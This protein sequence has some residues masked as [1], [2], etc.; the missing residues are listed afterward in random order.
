MNFLR[1][2]ILPL[3]F[4]LVGCVSAEAVAAPPSAL[5][6]NDLLGCYAQVENGPI[7]MRVNKEVGHY[8]LVAI[9]KD[10]STKGMLTLHSREVKASKTQDAR[11]IDALIS[12]DLGVI[13]IIK[14]KKGARMHGEPPASAFYLYAPQVG[15]P[16]FKKTCPQVQ[17]H[18]P[19][20][21]PSGPR[22]AA[23]QLTR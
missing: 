3:L 21:H 2:A 13:A 6:E 14:F 19:T 1:N 20:S 8:S 18:D 5:R 15:G 23:D 17:D 11:E 4:V 7:T 22:S 16:L 12:D 10:G 9:D